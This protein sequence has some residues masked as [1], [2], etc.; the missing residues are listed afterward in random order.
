MLTTSAL[1]ADI[2]S[3]YRKYANCYIIKPI[4]IADFMAAVLKIKDFW[5]KFGAIA[6]AD[7]LS[8]AVS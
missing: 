5:I 1:E 7:G 2:K 4:E 6:C 3:T 8:N